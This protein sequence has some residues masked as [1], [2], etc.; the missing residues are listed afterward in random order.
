MKMDSPRGTTHFDG[1]E[2]DTQLLLE[3][4][5]NDLR[6]DLVSLIVKVILCTTEK[7]IDARRF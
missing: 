6:S 3:I 4:L 2:K 1:S 5:Y 7:Y